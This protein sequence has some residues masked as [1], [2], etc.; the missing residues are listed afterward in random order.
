MMTKP[1]FTPDPPPYLQGMSVEQAFPLFVDW[2]IRQNYRQEDW[3]PKDYEE[4]I[5]TLE[6][7]SPYCI[8]EWT[9]ADAA[10]MNFGYRGR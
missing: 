9:I 6:R 5:Q 10:Y 8:G 4:R 7:L 1:K 3:W 2:M